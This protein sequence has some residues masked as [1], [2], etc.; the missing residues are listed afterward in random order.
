MGVRSYLQLVRL[1]N[2]FTAAADS[3]AGWLIAGGEARTAG[4]ELCLMLASMCLYAGGIALNDLCDVEVDR[5]ERPQRPLPSGAVPLVH[6]R[7]LTLVLFVVGLAAAAASWQS[8]GLGVAVVLV[9]MVIAYDLLLRRTAFGPVAMGACRGLNVL[10]GMSA[11]LPDLTT[12]MWLALVG[13]ALFVAGIT[14]FSR[15]EMESGRTGTLGWGLLVQNAGLALLVGAC[16]MLRVGIGREAGLAFIPTEGL[17]VLALAGLAVNRHAGRALAEPVPATIQSAIRTSI[18]SLIWL[19][20]GVVAGARGFAAAL[21]V[22]ALWIPARVA[23]RGLE[24]T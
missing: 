21:A 4:S 15:V 3:L 8:G 24:T 9:G 11:A 12:G 10:M 22:A 19:H 5:R 7:A 2:V 17:L 1:P 18:L 13:Y 23:A 14:L 20:V 16:L 6:A